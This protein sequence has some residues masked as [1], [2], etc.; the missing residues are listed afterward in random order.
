MGNMDEKVDRNESDSSGHR[1]MELFTAQEK[2]RQI[3][4]DE[5]Y[6]PIEPAMQK[7]LNRKFDLHITPWLFGFWLLAFLD[8]ANVGNAKIDGLPMDLGLKGN[9]FNVAL[10]IFYVPY[11]VIDIPAN[12]VVKKVKAGNYLPILLTSWGLVTTFQGFIKNYAGFLAVSGLLGRKG[13][14][15]A[16]RYRRLVSFLDCV[17]AVS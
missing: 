10:A 1:H 2:D 7:R 16:D 14:M 4:H 17:K 8:R 12:L 9:Q 5:D 11:I 15:M 13:H 3:S 6:L